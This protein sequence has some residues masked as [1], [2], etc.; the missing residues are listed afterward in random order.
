MPFNPLII[1]AFL[2]AV[3]GVCALPVFGAGMG[4]GVDRTLQLAVL[5]TE[6]ACCALLLLPAVGTR[7]ATVLRNLLIVLACF[8]AASACVMLLHFAARGDLPLQTR[9]GAFGAWMFAGAWLSLGARLG[10]DWL[11]RAR[12]LVLCVFALPALAH[13]LALE[14][15][16]SSLLH[17]RPVS[18]NWSL[19]VGDPN[20]CILLLWAALPLWALALALPPAKAAQ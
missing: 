16:G 6:L 20:A 2:L 1:V 10:R 13:Y 15:G 9:L 7:R 17:L 4:V 5:H 3:A 19:A 11:A 18:P 14:Y 12:L 8:A